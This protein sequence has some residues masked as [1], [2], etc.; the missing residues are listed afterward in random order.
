MRG[1][2]AMQLGCCYTRFQLGA[3]SHRPHVGEDTGERELRV[4]QGALPNAGPG[5][6]FGLILNDLLRYISLYFT[7]FWKIDFGN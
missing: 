2:G 7:L 3:L 5:G 4:Q 6:S 1:E